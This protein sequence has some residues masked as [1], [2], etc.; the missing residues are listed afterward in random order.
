MANVCS[1]FNYPFTKLPIYQISQDPERSRSERGPRADPPRGSPTG[2]RFR[3]ASARKRKRH[4]AKRRVSMCLPLA[5]YWKSLFGYNQPSPRPFYALNE[6]ALAR[7]AKEPSPGSE[8]ADVCRVWVSDLRFEPP[9][10]SVDT[11]NKIA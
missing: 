1:I 9:K 6:I 5:M 11:A 4:P 10:I 8:A 3:V 2:L 7:R